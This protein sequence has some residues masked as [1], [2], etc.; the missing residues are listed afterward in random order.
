MLPSAQPPEADLF[1][2]KY[3]INHV[4]YASDCKGDCQSYNDI[5]STVSVENDSS[6]ENIRIMVWNVQGLGTKFL[7][8]DFLLNIFEYDVIILLETMKLDT[9]QPNTG[10]HIFKHY[11][12]K[13]QHPK[14]RKPSGGIGILIRENL[15]SSNVVSIAKATDFVV[16]LRISQFDK[17][18]VMHLGGVYVP[19][20]D[21]TSTFSSFKNNN[22]Y[23]LIQQ[24]ITHFSRIGSV[25]VCGDFNARTGSLSD[26]L[27]SPGKDSPCIINRET[28]PSQV[29]FPNKIRYSEDSKTNRYGKDLIDM[30]RSSNM[31]IMNGY[32]RNDKNTGQFTCYT[33]CGKSLIDY[34]ICDPICFESLQ[35]FKIMPL[36]SYSDHRSLT[37]AFKQLKLTST[38]Q[39]PERH[40]S[41]KTKKFFRYVFDPKSIVGITEQLQSHNSQSLYDGMVHSVTSDKGVNDA[42]NKFYALLESAIAEN[43]TKKCQRPA[44]NTFPKNEWFDEE[45]K[46]LKR[47]TN[48][49]PKTH[50]LN[51]DDNLK[52]YHIHKRNYKA[53]TQKKKRQHYNK[54][55]EDLDELNSNSNEYW[56]YWNKINNN[57]AY[58]T[59]TNG[60]SLETFETYFKKIQSPPD[61]AVSKFDNGFLKQISEFVQC[62]DSSTIEPSVTDQ[63]ITVNEVQQAMDSL[64]FGKAPGIDGICNDFY[65]YL[66]NH[67]CQPLALLFNYIWERGIYPDK[68][69]E[70]IIQPLHKKGNIN[71][72]D[73]YRKL[74]LM[75]SMGKIFESIINKRFIFQTETMNVEDPHQFGFTRDCRTSDNVFIL[76]T[77][78]SFQ[79]SEK[80]QL[81]VAFIDFSKA[82]DYVNRTFLYYKMLKT[83][84]SNKLLKIIQSMFSQA[85]A[86]VRWHGKL[87]SEINSTFGVLQGGIVSPKLFNLYLSDLKEYLDES[88]GVTIYGTTFTHLLYADDLVLISENSKGLQT[89]LENLGNYCKK[90]HLIINY[91]KSKVMQFGKAGN[92]KEVTVLTIEG[93]TLEI[94]SSYKYLGHVISSS[95]N[96]HKIMYEH[97]AVQAQR[98]MHSLK[99]KIKTSVGYLTPKLS[100]KMF[101]THILPILEYHSEIWF[102]LKEISDLEKIQLKFLKNML[103]VR[104]QTSTVAVLADTGRFPLFVRQQVSAIKYLDRLNSNTCPLLVRKCFEIQTQLHD[105]SSTCWLSRLHKAMSQL[106]QTINFNRPSLTINSIYE[107]IQNKM[108]SEINDSAMNPKLRTYKHFKLEARIESYLNGNFPRSIYSNIARLRLVSHN[109]N[110]ELGRHKRPLVPAE[111]RICEK[112]GLDEVED[113]F[114]CIMKCEK[115]AELR[116]NLIQSACNAIDGFLVLNP[117]EQFCRILNN[118]NSNMTYSLGKFLQ[119]AFTN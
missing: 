109:L 108:F 1:H 84:Y 6:N 94:V 49:F 80:K 89:L 47:R 14:A 7:E 38:Q 110:I 9:Y 45:C 39:N 83:G 67:L 59:S 25:A 52:Q 79:K 68:W 119:K 99:E 102:S 40:D 74:T 18:E 64:K 57:A 95:V 34:L 53:L 76:D 82:F 51:I 116:L 10:K 78:I 12:R 4:N 2:S 70:G 23:H 69:T 24:D 54:I 88:C 58:K 61:H 98:A 85:T 105:K 96:I 90:W 100:I 112:C 111:Q 13:Y 104:Y 16:W 26:F 65:K 60:I 41:N 36:N 48:D 8:K 86:K 21:S 28:P 97:L 35:Y 43:C 19:P 42:V 50:D 20:L 71:E 22:A 66:S 30:C 93:E 91:Q 56:K 27:F 118:Q 75:A 92:R 106:G 55:R 81:H 107:T 87:G 63:P 17:N 46:C 29:S 117:Y 62:Y 5:E 44:T 37:F 31:R 77:L 72:A 11:Q 32:Y 3:C 73:N 103:G 114:H 113:E 101:D 115:W 15:Y 33:P